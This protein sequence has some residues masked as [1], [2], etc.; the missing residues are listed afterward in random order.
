MEQVTLM[1]VKDD[2]QPP[3]REM[4]CRR[5]ARKAQGLQAGALSYGVKAVKMLGRIGGLKE[6]GILTPGTVVG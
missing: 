4:D 2:G 5:E 1:E 3:H 6:K